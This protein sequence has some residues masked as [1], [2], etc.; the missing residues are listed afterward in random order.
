MVNAVRKETVDYAKEHSIDM[1]QTPDKLRARSKK[2]VCKTFHGAGLVVPFDKQTDIGYRPLLETDAALKKILAKLETNGK[3]TTKPPIDAV[4]AQLQPI[5]TMA[6]IGK[7]GDAMSDWPRKSNNNNNQLLIIAAVDESDFGTP[8]EL[9]LD[10]FCN[11]SPEL[12][13]LAKQLLIMGYSL[14][15]RPHFIAVLKVSALLENVY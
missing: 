3:A 14:V 10:L 4:K 13:D 6:T 1:E 5:I 7:S 11:G 8:I 12:H 2:V 9:G 15:Q